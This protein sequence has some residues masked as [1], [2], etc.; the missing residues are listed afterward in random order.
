MDN[1]KVILVIDDERVIR[2]IISF[3][4]ERKGYRSVLVESAHEA[5]EALA[6][7]QIDLV[8]CDVNLG[9]MNGFELCERVRAMDHYRALPFIFLTAKDSD[10]NRTMAI[11]VGADDFVTKPFNIDNLMLKIEGLLKRVEIYKNYGTREKAEK[12]LVTE[13]KRVMI[14][15][16][17][18]FIMEML[19]RS[20]QN[21]GIEV[22]SSLDA[23]SAMDVIQSFSPDIILSDIT[24]PGID[25]FEFRQMLL[26]DPR[27]KE[28]PFVFLTST[29]SDS[30]MIESFNY[31]I[32]DYIVKTTRPQVLVAK[33][34]NIINSTRKD[35]QTAVRELKEVADKLAVDA[36][37][38]V[39]PCVNG[40]DL[41]QWHLPFKE[42]PGGDFIDYIE[43]DK[44]RTVIILGDVMGKKWG[45]WFFT[46]SFIG[47]LRSSIRIAINSLTEF[48]AGSILDSVNSAIYKDSK[49]SEV[50][51]AVSVVIV[52]ARD[53][54]IQYSGAGD[55]PALILRKATSTIEKISTDNS[56]L[57]ILP[58]TKYDFAR[59]SLS[60]GDSFFI[61]SDGLTDMRNSDGVE[62]G[63]MGIE[64]LLNE[65]SQT[66]LL[67][68][69]KEKVTEFCGARFDDD[70]S[71]V[72][73]KAL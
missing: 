10:E 25:G 12:F 14:V 61:F 33:I 62:L 26:A 51:S 30:V 63:Y 13:N 34:N 65:Q 28:I 42:I 23:H 27:V 6:K 37:P 48:T 38:F 15:D 40:F 22:R 19:T 17:D 46:F 59:V 20:F 8:L 56:L 53:K 24:M 71:L 58:N 64:K 70:I 32:K 21:V 57:G 68:Y 55:L 49:V 36:A 16:D 60:P 67:E 18:P 69:I 73:I 11:S 66:E 2:K 50:F 1:N 54:S 31:E 5:F 35:K 39:S 4:L 7:G 45:A 9:G 47:Y 41:E 43:I 29:D 3:N 44:N 72:S 52:D